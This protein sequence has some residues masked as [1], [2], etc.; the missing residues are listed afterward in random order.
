M[1]TWASTPADTQLTVQNNVNG[2]RA[3]LVALAK[4]VQTAVVLDAEYTA[5]VKPILDAFAVGEAVPATSGP[6]PTNF[7]GAQPLAPADVASVHALFSPL[8]ALQQSAT[9]NLCIKAAGSVNIL[10]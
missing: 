8:V 10:S 2:Q 4:L 3:I 1:S 6:A 9:L 7:V 5:T